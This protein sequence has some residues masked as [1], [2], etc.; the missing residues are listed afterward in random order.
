MKEQRKIR[1]LH[2]VGIQPSTPIRPHVGTGVRVDRA[3]VNRDG[4]ELMLV[5]PRRRR[6]E[7]SSRLGGGSSF[8]KRLAGRVR[9]VESR[10]LTRHPT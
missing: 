1:K 10:D 7:N 2:R 8:G 6:G 4:Y 9:D 5:P 3:R